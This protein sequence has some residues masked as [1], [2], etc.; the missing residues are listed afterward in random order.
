MSFENVTP[1]SH[2]SVTP[3][4]VAS[5]EARNH[6]LPGNLA[7]MLSA[8]CLPL[9]NCR[10]DFISLVDGSVLGVNWGLWWANELFS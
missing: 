9:T 3:L 1:L 5:Q 8:N 10:N 2:L 4:R 7:N 6:L